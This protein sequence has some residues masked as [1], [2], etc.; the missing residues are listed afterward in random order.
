MPTTILDVPSLIRESGPELLAYMKKRQ[1]EKELSNADIIKYTGIPQTSFYRFWNSDGNHMDHDNVARICLLLGIS[2]DEFRR[3]PTDESKANLPILENSH[4][5]VMNN[6]HS[7]INKQK[8]TITEL[9]EE[10]EG[11]EAEIQALEAEVKLKTDEIIALHTRYAD[12][13]D[14]LKDALLERHDQMHELNKQHNARV[15]LLNKELKSRYDQLYQFFCEV[16][17]HNP[18]KL[19]KMLEDAGKNED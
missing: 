7:E 4:E 1:K 12:R 6:I 2:I 14:K 18:N 8:Q 13:V 19:M 5:D 15:D 16:V 10:I 9:H 11:L 3:T 17:S